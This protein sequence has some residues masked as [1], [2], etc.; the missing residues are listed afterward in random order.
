MVASLYSYVTEH[1][2]IVKS[3]RLAMELVGL[4]NKHGRVEADTGCTDD[5][6]L[7]SAVAFYVRQY[8]PPLLLTGRASEVTD[9]FTDIMDMNLRQSIRGEQLSANH[10]DEK[11]VDED[12]KELLDELED[13]RRTNRID[14]SQGA[15]IDTLSMYNKS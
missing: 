5:L 6:C 10:L 2:E 3:K 7:S 13:K 4:V 11:D 14:I 15:F 1:P 8:D 9:Q 12:L